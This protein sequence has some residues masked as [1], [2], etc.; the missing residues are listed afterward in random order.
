M[1]ILHGEKSEPNYF[2][3]FRVTSAVVVVIGL[4]KDTKRGTYPLTSCLILN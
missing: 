1:I 4:G 3:A 2:K